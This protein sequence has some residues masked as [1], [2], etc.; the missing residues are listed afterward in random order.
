MRTA[1]FQSRRLFSRRLQWAAGGTQLAVLGVLLGSLRCDATDL[2]PINMGVD[3]AS[4]LRI[5]PGVSDLSAAAAI[6][7]QSDRGIADL[8]GSDAGP[9]IDL[10]GIAG[11][12][13][14]AGTRDLAAWP[15]SRCSPWNRPIGDGAVLAAIDSPS[16]FHT[17]GD[18]RTTAAMN[19]ASWSHPVYLEDPGSGTAADVSGKNE[20]GSWTSF[21]LMLPSG[22]MP[23][24]G[25]DAHLHIISASRTS[26][27]EMFS[28]SITASGVSALALVVNDLQGAGVFDGQQ[29]PDREIWHGVRAYGGSAIGGLIRKGELASGIPHALA[30]AVRRAAMNKNTPNKLGYVWPASYRDDGWETTYGASG[31]LHMGSLLVLPGQLELP[32]LFASES[33]SSPQVQAVAVALQDYGAYVVD[34]TSD[35]ISFYAEPAEQAASAVDEA[36]LARLLPYLKVVTN[37]APS[38]VGGGGLPRRCLA[39]S[40]Q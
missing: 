3:L 11:A 36:E 31:V 9:A 39:P 30:V 19:S 18:P 33:I 28:A 4:D 23:A 7:L 24:A 2:T 37:S 1:P 16:F 25:S 29:S 27:Y 14:M 15:F 22:V 13:V 20:L 38:Q 8:Q 26:V 34:A 6:D 35:N 21:R 40:W 10:C 5:E 32:R 17:Q 12:C